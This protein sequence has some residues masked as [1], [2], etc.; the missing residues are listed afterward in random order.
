[1]CFFIQYIVCISSIA[2]LIHIAL[3]YPG[4]K[5]RAESMINSQSTITLRPPYSDGTAVSEAPFVLGGHNTDSGC[6][7]LN[8][9]N[10]KSNYTEKQISKNSRCAE[11]KYIIYRKEN[12]I[13]TEVNKYKVGK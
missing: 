13:K 1:M 10:A 5:R 7:Q 2:F 9:P 4:L 6:F 3:S 11:V 12:Q 8:S